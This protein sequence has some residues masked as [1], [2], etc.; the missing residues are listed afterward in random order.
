MRI[1][2]IGFFENTQPNKAVNACYVSL[3]YYAP[4]I[5]KEYTH[6]FIDRKMESMNIDVKW[7]MRPL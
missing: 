4:S 7:Q 3:W 1:S 2:C 5:N 6:P